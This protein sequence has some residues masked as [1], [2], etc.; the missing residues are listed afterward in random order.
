MASHVS[1]T[2]HA[3]CQHAWHTLKAKNIGSQI[4]FVGGGCS[5]L[6]SVGAAMR[7]RR[8]GKKEGR[9]GEEKGR[10]RKEKEIRKEEKKKGEERK[11][12]EEKEGVSHSEETQTTKNSELRYER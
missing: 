10:K 5:K 9:K 7:R 11:K 3:M 2:W 8:K 6:Q 1:D 12:K 4:Q